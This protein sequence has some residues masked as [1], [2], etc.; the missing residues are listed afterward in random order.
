MT[1][2]ATMHRSDGGL[3][4]RRSRRMTAVAGILAV[5][6]SIGYVPHGVDITGDQSRRSMAASVTTIAAADPSAPVGDDAVLATDPVDSTTVFTPD[7]R[8]GDL[9]LDGAADTL[10]VPYTPA[11]AATTVLDVPYGTDPAQ[12]LDLYLPSNTNAPVVIFAHAGGWIAGGREHVP[13][14]VLRFVERGVAVVSVG[15][16]LA[17]EHPFPAPVH[18]L[19]TAIRWVKAHGDRTGAFDPGRVVLYGASAGGHLVTFAAATPGR[20]EP[21]HLAPALA[22]HDT[23]V[24]GVISVVGPTDLVSFESHDNPWARPLA[25]AF[26]GCAPCSAGQ[27][28]EASPIHQLDGELPPA[29]FVYG[30]DDPLVDATTQAVP[31]AAAWAAAGAGSVS[32]DLVDGVGHNLDGGTVNQRAIEAFVDR[33]A[34]AQAA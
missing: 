16:R 31:I 27:L 3:E 30:A 6:V 8:P 17:P 9:R 28:R 18:D 34:A 23:S 1:T 4:H 2:S 15:Y 25:E 24:A 29:H 11:A 32:L 21:P 26:V 13:P 19:N 20:F 7:P 10:P 5:A 33:V 22:A 12:R 14:M